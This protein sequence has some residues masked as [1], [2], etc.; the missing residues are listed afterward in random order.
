MTP[1]GS[2]QPVKARE[3]PARD[4]DA[5]SVSIERDLEPEP[6]PAPTPPE[7]TEPVVS[8]SI[9][10]PP[11]KGETGPDSPTCAFCGRPI[12][13]LEYAWPDWVCDF[14]TGHQK[15]WDVQRTEPG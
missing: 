8:E 6:I 1:P 3:R 4:A 7:P 5:E 13:A 9:T 10:P 15:N 14:L 12:E 2:W 11:A